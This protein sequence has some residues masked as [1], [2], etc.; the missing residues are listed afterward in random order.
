MQFYDVNRF[1]HLHEVVAKDKPYRGSTNVYPLG[2]RRYSDRHFVV[3]DDGTYDVWYLD[4]TYA[5]NLRNN[6]LS[7]GEKNHASFHE[8]C[9]LGV[10]HPD[11]S[12]EFKNTHGQGPNMLMTEGIGMRVHHDVKR[13]GTVVEGGSVAHPVFRGLRIDL[14]TGAALTPY[15]VHIRKAKRKECKDY[16][17]QYDQKIDVAFKMMEAMT[18]DGLK[19]VYRDLFEQ[20]STKSESF[21]VKTLMQTDGA[22]VN[23]LFDKG[24]GVDA[25]CLYSVIAQHGTYGLLRDYDVR[26]LFSE[27]NYSRLD[28]LGTQRYVN[29]LK[30]NT[31]KH[32][33][34]HLLDHAPKDLQSTLFDFEIA[35][36]ETLPT[37]K[38]GI[39][40]TLADGTPV[41]RL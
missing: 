5:D 29:I 34:T 26:N 16:Y 31:N 41:H 8:A 24:F 15:Q 18:V 39:S 40:V 22:E 27:H 4:K 1:K 35:P 25:L 21:R 17:A 36:K 14:N 13:G 7:E 23:K 33:R 2:Q 30:A 11:K 3:K 38:W 6:T 28:A 10:V 20:Y 12:F 37:S 32:L 9:F 19:E